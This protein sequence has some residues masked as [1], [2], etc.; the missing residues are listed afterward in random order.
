MQAEEIR[1]VHG[2]NAGQ[3]ALATTTET[4]STT[5]VVIVSGATLMKTGATNVMEALAQSSPSITSP[6]LGATGSNALV[7]TM[8]LRGLSADDT[9]ILVNG[10]R[11]H[12]GAN[13][14]PNAGPNWGTE[15]TDIAL[16]PISAIDHIEVIT[17]GATAL[18]GQDAIAGAVNIVLKQ[19][20]DGGTINFKNSGFYAGDGQA[21]DGSAH[22]GMAVGQRGSFN[23]SAQVTHQLPTNRSGLFNGTLYP[24]LAGGVPD[25][26]NATDSRDVQ[27]IM[28]IP[29]STM[30]TISAV[31]NLPVTNTIN[32]YNTSTFSHR[33]SHVALTYQSAASSLTTPALWPNGMLPY[34]GLDQYDFETDTG[35]KGTLGGF[36]WD[37]YTNFARDQQDY[38]TIHTNNITLGTMSPTDFDD[39]ASIVSELTSGF[40][41][42]RAFATALLPRPI[43]LDFGFEYRHDTFQMTEGE[44]GS[45]YGRGASDHAGN[46][47]FAATN[48]NRDVY[49][50]HVNLEFYL[51]PKWEWTIG[52]R[53]VS[54]NNLATIETGSVGTRYNF[55]KHFAV[56]ASFNTG[57][58][59]PTL[60]QQYFYYN[61]PFAG[62]SQDQLPSNSEAARALGG[63]PLKG[64]YSRNYSIGFEASPIENMHL[65]GNLYYI[66]INDR[67]ASTTALGGPAVA[68]ILSQAGLG[69]VTYASYYTNPVNTQ[70]YGGDFSLDY[71]WN[72][73][74]YGS[75]DFRVGVNFSDN[76][77]RSYNKT[78]AVLK[79]LG[80][81]SFNT[82]AEEI[83]LHTSPKNREN[84]DITWKYGRWSIFAQEQRYGSTLFLP[85][86]ALP[87]VS[88]NP[89]MLTNLE[90]SY[91]ILPRWAVA[92]GGRNIGNKY[93]TRVPYAIRGKLQN[94]SLYSYFGPYGFSGG[95]YYVRTSLDF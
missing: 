90:V 46:Q 67:L 8:Q 29:K 30:E 14:N 77:I 92:V 54:Y 65:I 87:G 13:F 15:P 40:R 41:A 81:Q 37:V 72:T 75:F 95:M 28:G 11:R 85:S 45:W 16:I 20:T 58:R 22:Y 33:A 47:P 9:L 24:A 10:H 73:G 61:A 52:G 59:P 26:R 93:P 44:Y 3:G 21:L 80:L 63:G 49:D 57:Y 94:Q 25:P 79:N 64:E 66:A 69:G 70:T 2:T 42:S 78:P 86:P 7:Q 43:N 71:L 34:L 91:R 36:A 4:H 62:Y 89:A 53:S 38:S 12:I 32:L 50:G 74:R 51:T 83:L 35:F 5:S 27:R 1:V 31:T 48:Q 19:G 88:E 55:S 6:P 18:Y 68:N 23:I 39:G 60:G 17:E 56:R 76:E 82:Y 84:L